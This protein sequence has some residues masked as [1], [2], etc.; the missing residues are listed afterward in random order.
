MPRK[1]STPA[2]GV[3]AMGAAAGILGSLVLAA[4]ASQLS[5]VM[6]GIGVIGVLITVG[7]F[8][9]PRFA[10]LVLCASLPLERIGR[11]T[12]DAD[13]IAISASRILGLLALASVLLHMAIRKEKL[14]FGLPLWLYAGYTGIALMSNAWADSPEETYRDGFRIIGNLL[15]FFLIINGIR[16]FAMV[17]TAIV[18][19]LLASFGAGAFSVVDYYLFSRDTVTER[20]MGLTSER[21]ATVLEDG[22][23]ARSLGVNV[24]RLFGTTAHPTLFGLNM[25]MT[26]PFLIWVQRTRRGWLQLF[27]PPALVI[28]AF[29]I[30]LSNTRAILLLAGV[31]VLMCLWRRLWRPSVQMLISLLLVGVTVIPF[32]PEDVYRRT[33][34]PSLYTL[35]GADGLRVRLKYWQKSYEIIQET[36]WRGIGVGNQTRVVDMITD[37]TTGNL[38]PEG[39]RA[40]AHNEYIWVLAEVGLGGYLLHW[41]FVALVTGAGFRAAARFRRLP[42]CRDEYVFTLACQVLMVGVLLFA[43]QS[44]AFHYPLKAW[45]L[46]AGLA[47]TMLSLARQNEAA[48][49]DAHRQRLTVA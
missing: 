8:A 34:D 42:E 46:T 24:K 10:V 33:L 4:L 25:L 22:A 38:T 41:G 36:W 11:L 12:D 17:K 26:V 44:E 49:E 7:M 29:A 32:I 1:V 18:V 16:T 39:P 13:P 9:S 27:W 28:A 3:L 14:T 35:S 47:V 19:W 23:E 2:Y 6:A 43:V 5:P 30:V 45:W 31:T 40:S 15:F 48:R 37:E 20:Q 21:R